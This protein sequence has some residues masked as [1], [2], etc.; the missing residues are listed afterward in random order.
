MYFSKNSSFYKYNLKNGVSTENI[1]KNIN[2]S[3]FVYVL[4]AL[5]AIFFFINA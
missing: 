4:F 1:L 3:G 5:Y 2:N